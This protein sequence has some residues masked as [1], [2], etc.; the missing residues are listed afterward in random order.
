LQVHNVLCHK[1][2]DTHLASGYLMVLEL[3]AFD[4]IKVDQIDQVLHIS[5]CRTPS[6]SC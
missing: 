5:E 2:A 6:F 3:S 1:A 4:G